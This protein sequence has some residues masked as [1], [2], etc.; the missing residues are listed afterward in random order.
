MLSVDPRWR[1][2]GIGALLIQAAVD[3]M[4]QRGA[5]EIVLETEAD[6]AAALRLYERLGFLREK[7]LF[8]FYMNGTFHPDTKARTRSGWSFRSQL[9]LVG[10]QRLRCRRLGTLLS[11][12]PFFSLL[13]ILFAL[14]LCSL[15]LGL[16]AIV[17]K[18]GRKNVAGEHEV[19][20][21]RRQSARKH[22]VAAEQPVLGVVVR[23]NRRDKQRHAENGQLVI[24]AAVSVKHVPC[25][26][27]ATRRHTRRRHFDRRHGAGRQVEVENVEQ[28]PWPPRAKCTSSC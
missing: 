26:V 3:A 19:S 9:P 28:R 1:G 12:V 5:A 6:N 18:E 23:G 2:R 17:F 13:Y 27:G 15:G 10:F 22:G 11:P 24:H 20:D 8:R 16:A 14:F 4:V 25:R 7:R 21:N